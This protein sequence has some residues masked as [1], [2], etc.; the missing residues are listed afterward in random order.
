MI[1]INNLL[2]QSSSI[3]DKNTL[4]GSMLKN[5]PINRLDSRPLKI[6]TFVDDCGVPYGTGV[7]RRERNYPA[8]DI[9]SLARDMKCLV[10]E[11]RC[12]VGNTK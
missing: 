4:S 12:P 8:R 11:K 10:G 7:S 6:N 5:K 3:Q 2:K 1:L 9:S